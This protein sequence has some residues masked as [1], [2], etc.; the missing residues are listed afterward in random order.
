MGTI[1]RGR[2]K[3]GDTPHGGH[4]HAHG[5]HAEDQEGYFGG[6]GLPETVGWHVSA[7]L[8]WIAGLTVLTIERATGGEAFSPVVGIL[9]TITLAIVPLLVLGA[10]YLPTVWWGPYVRILLPLFILGLGAASV[11]DEIGALVLITMFPV[12]AVAYLHSAKIALPYCLFGIGNMVGA[13]AIWDPYPGKW[14]RIVVLGGALTAVTFGLIYAQRRLRRA[15]T[16]NL[17]LSVTDHLTGLANLRRLQARLRHEI[18]RSARSGSRIVLFAI[19]LDDFKLVNDNF[20][21]ELGDRVLRAVAKS[22]GELMCPGDLLV[23][24]GGDEFAVLTLETPDRDLD[25]FRRE[26]ADA[27]ARAR[28]TVCP[29]VNPQA[30]VTYTRHRAGESAAAF[31]QR[32]DDNLHAAK[33]D[34]HPERRAEDAKHGDVSAVRHIFGIE[35]E[36]ESPVSIRTVGGRG[37]ARRGDHRAAWSFIAA[38]AIVPSALL[39]TVAWTGLAPGLRGSALAACV[40]GSLAMMALS[41]IAR[42]RR[43]PLRWLHIPLAVSTLLMTIAIADAGESKQALLELYAIQP[44]LAIYILSPINA[45][46]YIVASCYFYSYFLLSSGFPNSVIRIMIFVGAMAV[47]CLMLMRGQ[48]AAREYARSAAEMSVVDPLTGVGNLRGLHQRVEDEVDRCRLTGDGLALMVVDLDGFKHVNDRFS[49]TMGD[50]VLIETANAIR[51]T[52]REDELVARRGGDEFAIVC[53]PDAHDDIAVLAERVAEAIHEAR[54]RLTSG[55]PTTATVRYILWDGQEDA[56]SFL[57]RADVELHD[58]KALRDS[59]AA[60]ALSA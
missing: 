51:A 19:D 31:L 34:A 13:L 60:G 15:A 9:A 18:Q 59:G 26:I 35:T 23:R 37:A 12:L 10:R 29:E 28:L 43:W 42:Q 57:R 25:E 17:R 54:S 48:R 14:A 53:S 44:P 56:E 7:A 50:S 5:A 22:L 1:T 52:V 32:V 40:L 21:Y 16:L 20:S 45:A 47:L 8:Y 27:I 58:A 46:P 39:A 4:G 11:G 41:L 38:G 24:R 30:S 3:G 2:R 36:E 6:I 49:H 55:V 33:L